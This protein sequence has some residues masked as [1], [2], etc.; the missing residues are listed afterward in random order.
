L[1]GF[2]EFLDLVV[3]RDPAGFLP[4]FLWLSTR[5]IMIEKTLAEQSHYSTNQ[6]IEHR[7]KEMLFF[8]SRVLICQPKP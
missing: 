5:L 8:S 7:D 2:T 1:Y 4:G 3:S 6:Q